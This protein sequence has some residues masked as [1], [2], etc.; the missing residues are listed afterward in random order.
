MTAP[1]ILM[2]RCLVDA[3]G[4]FLVNPPACNLCRNAPD[5]AAG[6]PAHHA[7]ALD[8]CEDHIVPMIRQRQWRLQNNPHKRAQVLTKKN[9]CGSNDLAY[10][11]TTNSGG[12]RAMKFYDV[13][14]LW[15]AE[16]PRI[17][18]EFEH[19]TRL[20]YRN[21]NACGYG[22]KIAETKLKYLLQSGRA[23][24]IAA[25]TQLAFAHV[26]CDNNAMEII[27]SPQPV[28]LS[29]LE[30]VM[31]A[32]RVF[33]QS[34]KEIITAAPAV[35]GPMGVMQRFTTDTAIFN[36]FSTKVNGCSWKPRSCNRRTQLFQFD[37]LPGKPAPP[38]DGMEGFLNGDRQAYSIQASFDLSLEQLGST[39][40]A[41][42]VNSLLVAGDDPDRMRCRFVTRRHRL[43]C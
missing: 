20:K 16:L 22:V 25:G 31:D 24:A 11:P 36:G 34:A 26:E 13:A 6:L 28:V 21:A 18:F 1:G 17:G 4:A 10:D 42:N 9:V 15:D 29:A 19:L 30:T 41:P 8:I 12:E 33:D 38:N 5:V 32:M 40:A 27:I 35:A 7:P 39:R 3:N 14:F 23:A 2:C 37:V 43:V